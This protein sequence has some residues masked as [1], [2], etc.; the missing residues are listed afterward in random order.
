MP[1]NPV[2]PDL[3]LARA[4]AGGAGFLT[5]KGF[6]WPPGYVVFLA[7]LVSPEG[8]VAAAPRV[9]QSV[10]GALLVLPAAAFAGFALVIGLFPQVFVGIA[11]T[12]SAQLLD[13]AP[14]VAAVLGAR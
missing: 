13:P 2:C 3:E 9:L 7:P 8:A 10:L 14:Y 11:Q 5:E 4:L 12:A 1:V 6:L